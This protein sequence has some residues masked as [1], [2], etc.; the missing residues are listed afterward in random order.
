MMCGNEKIRYVHI[1]EHKEVEEYFRVGCICAE[2][3]TNDYVNPQKRE[4]DLRNRASRRMNWIKKE[5]KV[6]I[7]GYYYLNVNGKHLLIYRDK[8]TRKYKIKIGE[9]FIN[10]L[11]EN[12]KEAK[13]YIF[14]KI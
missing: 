14:D 5:W 8:K 13:N 1:V 2:K 11:F 10:K 7:K 4:K 12:L 6:S 3:M 9:D